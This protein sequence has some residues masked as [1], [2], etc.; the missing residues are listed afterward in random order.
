MCFQEKKSMCKQAA[1]DQDDDSTVVVKRE[2]KLDS[3][4][5]MIQSTNSASPKL[6]KPAADSSSKDEEVFPMFKLKWI[7]DSELPR[8]MGATATLEI[9][10][11]IDRDAQA[12]YE[13]ALKINKELKGI[14]ARKMK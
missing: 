9:E 7:G 4:N 2:K 8:D 10:T 1:S 6:K 5:P 11:E 13:N 14:T 3:S 12:I